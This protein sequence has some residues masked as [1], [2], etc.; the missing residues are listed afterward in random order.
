MFVSLEIL[1]NPDPEINTNHRGSELARDEAITFN[2][3]V[4]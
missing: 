1:S 3:D 4:A 2:I